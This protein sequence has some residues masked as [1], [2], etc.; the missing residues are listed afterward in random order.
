MELKEIKINNEK[1]SEDNIDNTENIVKS[2]Q[3]LPTS[4]KDKG[5]YEELHLLN[6]QKKLETNNSNEK[7]LSKS[8]YQ[9]KAYFNINRKGKMKMFL[10]NNKGKPL[11]AI[12]PDWIFSFSLMAFLDIISFCYLFFLRNLLLRF[13]LYL[14]IIIFSV[15]SSSFLMTVLLNP[16]IVP[17]ELWL[18]NYKHLDEIGS[19]RICNICKIIMRNDDKTDHCEDCNICIIGADH[20]CPWTSKCVGKKNK[21]LFKIFVFSTFI[22]LIYFICGVLSIMALL[23]EK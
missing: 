18:E 16:G 3:V 5:D 22:L 20:H 10:F 19:Y 1:Q 13:M 11:I 12:G 6:S 14:G 15:Q 2:N 8:S 23:D 21:K 17:K 9:S 4:S 7:N